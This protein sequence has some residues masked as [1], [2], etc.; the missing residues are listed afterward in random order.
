MSEPMD[1]GTKALIGVG[2]SAGVLGGIV[3]YNYPQKYWI[4]WL[5]IGMGCGATTG[6]VGFF[7]FLD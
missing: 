3:I 2:I 1:K 7:M 4:P 6:L 5:L